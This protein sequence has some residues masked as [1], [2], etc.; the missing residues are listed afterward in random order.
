M[1]NYRPNGFTMGSML[2]KSK[3]L[4]FIKKMNPAINICYSGIGADEV[5]ALNSFYSQGYGNVD[6]FPKQ[7]ESVFPWPNFYNGS[8]KN[9]LKGD[10]YIGGTFSFET[11]Y[12]FCDKDLVQEFLNLTSELKNSFNG[13]NYKPALTYYL[14]KENFP[15][16]CNK[17]GF[18][19]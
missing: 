9:Y 10:E 2:G 18:N 14:Q 19:V 6:I 7:L 12:P 11:R 8:M 5:M 17:Y 4:D 13:I 1:R 3:I 15:Y 16:Q